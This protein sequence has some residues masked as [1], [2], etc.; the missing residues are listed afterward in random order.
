MALG[1]VDGTKVPD[2]IE[3]IAAIEEDRASAHRKTLRAGIFRVAR[4]QNEIAPPP[5]KKKNN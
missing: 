4:L 3:E 2:M 5:P 1:M